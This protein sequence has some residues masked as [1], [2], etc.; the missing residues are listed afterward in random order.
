MAAGIAY[1]AYDT[2][3]RIDRRLGT[4]RDGL[5]ACS[6]DLPPAEASNPTAVKGRLASA[7]ELQATVDRAYDQR[8]A[9]VESYLRE[10]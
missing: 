2:Y 5:H 6:S 10:R 4:L 1:L 9:L 7:A 8:A 3:G